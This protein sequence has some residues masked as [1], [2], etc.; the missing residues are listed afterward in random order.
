MAY[1]D[2]GAF[3]FKNGERRTDKEDVAV[4]N[5]PE[6]TFGRTASE[7]PSVARC[8]LALIHAQETGKALDWF[9][10]VHHGVMGEGS[11]RV[12]C[13]KQ[14]IPFIYKLNDDGSIEQIDIPG[15]NDPFDWGV[16]KFEYEGYTFQFTSGE[17]NVA[18][19]TEPDGT[20]WRC[21][22]DYQYGAGF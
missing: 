7:V 21:E 10:K 6:E 11:I 13:H 4:F 3:V 2:Y 14:H 17:P 9:T 1:S 16:V 15:D 5:T 18:E 22:Y 8:V 20:E 19:M 12:V